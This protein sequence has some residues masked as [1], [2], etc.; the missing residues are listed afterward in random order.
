MSVGENIKDIRS[1]RGIKQYEL[2]EKLEISR[3]MMAQIERGTKIPSLILG[4]EIAKELDCRIEDLLT[5]E[6][7]RV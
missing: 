7:T 5:G 2:A 6:S 4:N 1:S 3:S